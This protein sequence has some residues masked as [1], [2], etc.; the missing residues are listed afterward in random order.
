[1]KLPR[2]LALLAACCAAAATSAAAGAASG[3]S[4]RTTTPIKHIVSLMQENHTYDNY[5][6]T[7]PKGNGI[8]HGVCM[9]VAPSRPSRGCI[10]PFHIG[11][12]GIVPRDLDHSEATSRRQLNGGRMNGFVHALTLRNQDGRLAMGYYDK[13]DL[14]YYWNLA[15]EYVL[16]DRFFSSAQGGSFVNH[17]YWVSGQSGGGEG[18]GILDNGIRGVPT[19]FDRLEARGI[20]WKFY[21]QNYDPRIT[22][23][24][25]SR[26]PGNRASQ[27][28]WAPLLNYPR[29]LDNPRLNRH[30]VDL[31]E[32]FRDLEQGTLPAVSYIVPSGPSEHPPSS[33]ASGQAFT[34]SLINALKR[35]SAWHSSAFLLAYDDYGGWYDHVRPPKIDRYGFGF[36]VPA[37]LVSPYARRGVVDSTELEFS[38]ILKFIEENWRIAPLAAR[39]RRANSIG[40]GFDFAAPPRPPRFVRADTPTLD[41]VSVRRPLIYVFYVGALVAAMAPVAWVFVRRLRGR[42]P[43]DGPTAEEGS[44]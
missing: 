38:S 10:K 8:P 15:R 40:A 4:D 37:L 13:R 17:I 9:P 24:S 18:E 21:I 29:F 6:G 22:Y 31:D 39:D 34:R 7:Y 12:N 27:V 11:D 25:H 3:P 5:F 44:S 28:I 41:N 20:S 36:R 35:S 2:S 26:F 30:I 43:P 16:Y 42:A 19:I 32:Y 23:R 14:P 1:V 33:L